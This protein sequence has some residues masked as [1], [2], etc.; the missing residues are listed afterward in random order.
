MPL[1]DPFAFTPIGAFDRLNAYFYCT[2]MRVHYYDFYEGGDAAIRDLVGATDSHRF[3]EILPFFPRVDV[4]TIGETGSLVLVRGTTDNIQL[5]QEVIL[6]NLVPAGD[7]GDGQ[8]SSFFREAALRVWEAIEDQV[9]DTWVSVGHSLGGALASLISAN[10]AAKILTA[11]APKEG[12]G[13]YA[14]SRPTP[15]K[16]RITN[17]H[18]PTPLIPLTTGTVFDFLPLQLPVGL[19]NAYRHWGIRRHLWN[20]GSVTMPPDD[21]SSLNDLKF[22]W[23]AFETG[24]WVDYHYAPE[25]CRRVRLGIPITFPAA[26]HDD[27]FPGLYELDQLNLAMNEDD[28]VDWNVSGNVAG[29]GPLVGPDFVSY[30][31][32]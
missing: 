18:D 7:F 32:G 22:F 17:A 23:E 12:N 6:S 10:G 2:W 28:E 13:S 31:C 5:A 26:A 1:I 21:R 29:N 25:Y 15:L 19:N 8:I 9:L 14:V 24:I 3:N 11:G 16:L 30:Q 4:L 27:D 20:D